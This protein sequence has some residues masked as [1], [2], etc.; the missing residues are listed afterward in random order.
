MRSNH[1]VTL[2]LPTWRLRD[3]YVECLKDFQAAEPDRPIKWDWLENF[4][5]DLEWCRR[6]REWTE[7]TNGRVPQTT[8][9]IVC[10][11]EHAVGKLTLR[12]KLTPEVERLGGHF[13]YEI[14]PAFRRRGIATQALALGLR[15]IRARGFTDV[16]ITC[17]D[18]N[19]GSIG[20]FEK[21]GGRHIAT[22]PV[23]NWPKPVRKYHFEL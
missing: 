12:H 19:L 14:R 22:Y 20:V 4:E 23:E 15:E 5:I 8:Y 17:D 18:D 13:G 9:W 1:V 2:D 16:F 6:E 21:N 3:C 7:V 11:G 10:D